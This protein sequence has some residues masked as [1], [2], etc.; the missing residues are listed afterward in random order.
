MLDILRQSVPAE[1]ESG[2]DASAGAGGTQENPFDGHRSE[3]TGNRSALAWASSTDSTSI[4]QET[5]SDLEGLSFDVSAPPSSSG[6]DTPSTSVPSQFDVLDNVGK[7]KA[8]IAIFPALKPFDITWTLKK[9]KWDASL[10]ID[11]LMT[12]SF[13]EESGTRHK[14]IEAFSEEAP[15]KPRKTKRKG[16]KLNRT[17]ETSK[18]PEDDRPLQ[19]KW[20]AG[21]QDIEFLSTKTGMPTAQISSLYHK[22]AASVRETILAITKAHNEMGMEVDPVIQINAYELQNDY[23]ALS[24]DDL[25]VLVEITYPSLSDARDLAKALCVPKVQSV[26]S[27]PGN[28]QIE[29]R[30]APILDD[31]P[32]PLPSRTKPSTDR[33]VDYATASNNAQDFRAAR[34]RAQAQASS[35]Y[36]KAK[37]D[38]LMGAAAGYYSQVGRDLGDRARVMESMAAD[39]LVAAQSSRT[40]L[41]LHGVNVKDALR[42][43]KERVTTWWH[44]L[45]E[46]KAAPG[47][48][49]GGFKIVT[50]VGKHSE[51][52]RGKLGPA[53][54]KMLIREGWKV[55]VGSG[56]LVVRGVVRR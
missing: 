11:E 22:N 36:R 10:A 56:S 21:K 4:S 46:L 12:Q 28:I 6:G 53:V 17:D 15:S 31:F 34:E 49:I 37:S 41:D 47:G 30:H 1:E 8:L 7:E 33:Q 38:P 48:Y 55:E 24:I 40:Q 14:G 44:E 20:D 18:S 32:S 35:A 42:I 39:S 27:K 43:S 29:F 54:G 5:L 45:G 9:L 52:G 13:L 50:G 3:S 19:S 25:E 16:K 51:G 2:F 26:S 23:P